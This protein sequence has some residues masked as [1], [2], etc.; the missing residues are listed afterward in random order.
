MEIINKK[1]CQGNYGR[2]YLGV[3]LILAGLLWLGYNFGVVSY[4]AFTNIFSWQV[5]LLL[6]GGYL[7][8]CCKWLAGA[9]VSGVAMCYIVT[10]LLHLNI[11][12]TK[13][14]LPIVVVV[15]GVGILTRQFIERR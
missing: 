10:D 5:L 13:V 4:F 15:L 11:P 14:V 3:I 8:S 12:F 7:L 6:I 9:I 1:G 2:I